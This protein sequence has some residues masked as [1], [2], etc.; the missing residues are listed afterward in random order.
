MSKFTDFQPWV[1][2]VP[3]HF[4]IGVACSDRH[5]GTPQAQQIAMIVEDDALG[6]ATIT[7]AELAHKTSQFAQV[8]RNLGIKAGD[9]VLIRLPNSLDYPIAFLGAM[10]IGRDFCAHFYFAHGRRSGV[11]CQGFRRQGAGDRC[12]RLGWYGRWSDGSA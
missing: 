2:S 6:T 11:S 12:R 3:E 7:F 8:L 5:L 10:K 9:R 1:W 4:N